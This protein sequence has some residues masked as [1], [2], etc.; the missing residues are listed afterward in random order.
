MAKSKTP[1]RPLREALQIRLGKVD[2]EAI[3]IGVGVGVAIGIGI[4]GKRDLAWKVRAQSVHNPGTTP[5]LDCSHSHSPSSN[6]S[7]PEFPKMG[8]PK[9]DTQW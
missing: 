1:P 9:P 4:D 6:H 8:L 5:T 3:K 7:G 2:G